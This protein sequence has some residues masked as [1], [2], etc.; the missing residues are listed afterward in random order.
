MRRKSQSLVTRYP[1]G[2][3]PW[4]MSRRLDV[5]LQSRTLGAAVLLA[6]R[7]LPGR[8]IDLQ[9]IDFSSH[10]AARYLDVGVPKGPALHLDELLG[11]E[12]LIESIVI[13]NRHVN[14]SP[15]PRTRS[16]CPAPTCPA[17]TRI[18]AGCRSKPR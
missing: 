4:I 3:R 16:S 11:V 2:F 7:G 5:C 15:I 10:A 14:S 17:R 1:L 18:R 8:R 9:R 13:L 6:Q 12:D